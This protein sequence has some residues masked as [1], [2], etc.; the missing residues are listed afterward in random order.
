MKTLLKPTHILLYFLSFFVFLFTGTVLAGYVGAGD[1]QGFAAAAIVLSY[2]LFTGFV[3]VVASMFFA[4]YLSQHVRR[5]NQFLLAIVVVFIAAAVYRFKKQQKSDQVDPT[6]APTQTTQAATF[7]PVTHNPEKRTISMG[8]GMYK[9]HFHKQR[10]LHF[11]SDPNLHKSVNEHL[12]IDSLIFEQT[13]YGIEITY[14][15]PWFNPKHLKLDYDILWMRIQSMGYEFAEVTVNESTGTTYFVSL[16]SGEAVY[17]PAFLLNV[18]SIDLHDNYPQTVR[19]KPL[20]HA[21]EVSTAFY[22]MQAVAVDGDWLQV[23]LKNENYEEKGIGW[24]R[25][26]NCDEMWVKWSILS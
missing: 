6:E 3:A 17:W 9:P 11:Y 24:I 12:P 5:T 4:Y 10:A 16:N 1:E 26:R 23:V 13:D 7:L 2:G 15:P 18:H 14:A 20:D 21:T 19:Y 25:W 22:A 8:L